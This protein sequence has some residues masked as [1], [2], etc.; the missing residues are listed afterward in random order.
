MKMKN[1]FS[2]SVFL[3]MK[4]KDYLELKKFLKLKN[5]INGHF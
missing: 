3:K 1:Y 2:V 5:E 4:M